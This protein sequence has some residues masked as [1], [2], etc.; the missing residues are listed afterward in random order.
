M[1]KTMITVLVTLILGIGSSV[2]TYGQ[3]Y[4]D[5]A[6]YD[7]MAYDDYEYRLNDA[8]ALLASYQGPIYYYQHSRADLFF[9]LIGRETF[10]VP[11]ATFRY[12]MHRPNF[13][14]IAQDAF[15][16]MS[17]GGLD[18][19]DNYLR[20]SYYFNY[21]LD[22]IFDRPH[23]SILRYNFR[24]Y[25]GKRHHHN[26]YERERRRYLDNYKHNYGNYNSNNY[27][28][29][30][31]NRYENRFNRDN[32]NDYRRSNNNDRRYYNNRDYRDN[33]DRRNNREYRNNQDHSNSRRISAS[34]YR[35]RD[36]RSSNSSHS[37]RRNR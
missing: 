17:C 28:N 23:C 16:S 27:H 2:L 30:G 26:D 34:A 11:A 4:D 9:V 24:S 20:F 10:I 8:T 32:S 19:Y 22:N 5:Y 15:I 13:R 3:Y 29:Y 31:S 33:Q 12:Y 21:F 25:Y 1:K 35:N 6:S 36:Q 7:N 37:N 18:Y 14:Y